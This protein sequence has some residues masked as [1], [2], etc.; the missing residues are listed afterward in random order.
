MTHGWMFPVCTEQTAGPGSARTRSL[1]CR[2]WWDARGRWEACDTGCRA[3]AVPPE[4]LQGWGPTSLIPGPY[5]PSKSFPE[6]K[7]QSWKLS[8]PSSTHPPLTR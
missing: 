2:R 4:P 1:K 7:F 3:L 5:T 6:I 8:R